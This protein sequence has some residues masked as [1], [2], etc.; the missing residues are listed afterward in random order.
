MPV[1]IVKRLR[2]T[3][4]PQPGPVLN[5][6]TF[7][8]TLLRSLPPSLPPAPTGMPL[9]PNPDAP[10]PRRPPP[11]PHLSLSSSYSFFLLLPSFFALL[12]KRANLYDRPSLGGSCFYH[13]FSLSGFL[14]VHHPRR[15]RARPSVR[16]YRVCIYVADLAHALAD[17]LSGPGAYHALGPSLPPSSQILSGLSAVHRPHRPALRRLQSVHR[18]AG[19][20]LPVD[21]PLCGEGKFGRVSVFQLRVV[22]VCLIRVGVL[23]GTEWGVWE[24]ESWSRRHE[25]R[26]IV[27]SL[28]PCSCS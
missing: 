6:I 22:D 28:G 23:G 8:D 3:I 18:R 26:K 7:P 11:L 10:R 14:F 1:A 25:R 20:P 2:Q 5:V 19:P 9:Q 24:G 12:K 4:Q 15:P 13:I 27:C 16:G 21:G 17:C